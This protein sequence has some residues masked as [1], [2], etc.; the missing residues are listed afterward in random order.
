M[1]CY[2]RFLK[3]QKKPPPNEGDGCVKEV[4]DKII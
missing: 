1:I 4:S 2:K 3:R